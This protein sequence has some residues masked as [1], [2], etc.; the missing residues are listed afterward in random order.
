MLLW[1][2]LLGLAASARRGCWPARV[3]RARPPAAG[4]AGSA[5]RRSWSS[6]LAWPYTKL[7]YLV[8]LTPLVVLLGIRVW[9]APPTRGERRLAWV[10]AAAWALLLA[11]TWGDIA[12]TAPDPRPVALDPAGRGRAGAAAAPAAAA[13]HQRR[14]RWARACAPRW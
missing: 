6:A 1:P 14:A 4:A 8:P 10:V 5:R 9:A 7:R 13:A 2:G 12:G 3:A 11:G